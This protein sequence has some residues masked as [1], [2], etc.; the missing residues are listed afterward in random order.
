MSKTIETLDDILEELANL[1]D[2]YGAC[3][4]D[5]SG[6]GCDLSKYKLCCRVGFMIDY[7]N[8][9]ERAIEVENALNKA[10]L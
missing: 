9:I 4:H 10:G 1:L 6:D 5:D 2:C 8:R 3:K 7:K